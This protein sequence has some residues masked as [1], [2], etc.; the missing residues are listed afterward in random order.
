MLE[1]ANNNVFPL[2]GD[3]AM[4]LFYNPLNLQVMRDSTLSRT[5]QLFLFKKCNK[6]FEDG[7]LLFH[8]YEQQRMFIVY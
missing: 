4:D 5:L 6:N 1:S 8:K 2:G 3:S 7:T